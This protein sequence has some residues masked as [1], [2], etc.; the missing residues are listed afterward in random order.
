M[1]DM[2]Q[3]FKIR[4]LSIKYIFLG[5]ALLLSF[6]RIFI[7]I[8]FTDSFYWLNII[9]NLSESP[10]PPVMV[11][12]TVA[13]GELW[14]SVFPATLIS[15]RI[16]A[17]LL[18]L[19]AT[20]LLYFCLIPRDKLKKNLHYLAIAILLSNK[21]VIYGIDSLSVFF[22]AAAL[23]LLIKYINNSKFLYL[24]IL[25]IVSSF[26]VFVRFPNLLL[27]F[28]VLFFILV[29]LL[30]KKE[31]DNRFITVVIHGL[32]FC[33]IYGLGFYVFSVLFMGNIDEYFQWLWYGSA[34]AVNSDN[35][36]SIFS[37]FDIISKDVI[38]IL[39]Y[40]SIL[41]L[42]SYLFRI[43]DAIRNLNFR[44]IVFMAILCF[45]ALL[46]YKMVLFTPFSRMFKLLVIA[47]YGYLAIMRLP[48]LIRQEKY[49][50]II[51]LLSIFAVSFISAAG[52]DTGLVKMN[53]LLIASFPLFLMKL[54]LNFKPAKKYLLLLVGLFFIL[55]FIEYSR[56][57]ED[58]RVDFLTAKSDRFGGVRTTEQR[59]R[60]IE[61]V[62]AEYQG[63]ARSN[64]DIILYGRKSH[65]FR[66][67]VQDEE[68]YDY[69][70]FM[71]LNNYQDVEK[72]SKRLKKSQPVIFLLTDYPEE[73][74]RRTEF[75]NS[76]LELLVLQKNYVVIQKKG[77][78]L[79]MPAD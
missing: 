20:C 27:F 30:Q 2:K 7:G 68:F 44:T 10:T 76:L 6:A 74:E 29:V 16:F 69:S 23:M 28:T 40:I 19:A 14:A 9:L 24:I 79:L 67:L 72:L 58:N 5:G 39:S 1:R 54:E 34:D 64:P 47:I 73:G 11:I 15:F 42:L 45:L 63:L 57:Y 48:L 13:L 50:N 25:A 62:L 78:K 56:P 4:F 70:Y 65:I 22:L 36:H 17:E 46:S 55:A 43:Q 33:L 52:S 77:Y 18:V 53:Y 12:G 66:Y 35:N 75:S 38:S 61:D 49:S 26:A 3:L 41:C 21:E 31:I 71:D 32:G 60:F 51:V 8:D 37:L 59:V